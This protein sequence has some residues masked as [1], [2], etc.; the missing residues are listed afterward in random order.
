M[1]MVVGER[2]QCWMTL[3]PVLPPRCGA[4]SEGEASASAEFLSCRGALGQ[5][6]SPDNFPFFLHGCEGSCCA[7]QGSRWSARS[8]AR[9]ND[10]EDGGGQQEASSR[11]EKKDQAIGASGGESPHWVR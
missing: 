4:R 1:V 6:R 11:Q 10:L 2:E 9:T 8:A 3:H 5:G 7:T